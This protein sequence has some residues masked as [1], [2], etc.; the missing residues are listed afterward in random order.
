MSGT[1]VV[2]TSIFSREAV[3]PRM[4]E[5]ETLIIKKWAAMPIAIVIRAR[6]GSVLPMLSRDV[7]GETL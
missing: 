1:G 3:N 2:W 5:V 7:E 4:V 6:V